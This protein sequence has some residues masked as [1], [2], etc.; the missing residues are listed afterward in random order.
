MYDALYLASGFSSG[1]YGL[2]QKVNW[3]GRNFSSPFGYEKE[4]Y[5]VRLNQETR[6]YELYA[7]CQTSGDLGISCRE[8]A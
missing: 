8:G 1:V 2:M 6:A 5:M 7:L 4:P 3:V